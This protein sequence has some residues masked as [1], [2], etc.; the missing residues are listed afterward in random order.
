MK[1]M[2]LHSK[3]LEDLPKVAKKI[4]EL[5]KTNKILTFSG[6][7]GA[8]KTTLISAICKELRVKDAISSPTYS[9]VNEYLDAEGSSIYHFDFYRIEDEE[10]ALDMGVE[11]YFYSGNLCLVEWPEK[12]EGLL[13]EN[14]LHIKINIEKSERIFNLEV[15]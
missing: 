2:E 11:E 5:T 7:M 13:P 4:V 8:G 1:K 9:L 3:Q 15:P 6:A 10:E 14:S 12:I